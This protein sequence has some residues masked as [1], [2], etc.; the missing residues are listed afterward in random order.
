MA[1]SLSIFSRRKNS[2]G[3]RTA[4]PKSP[5]RSTLKS[6][7][8]S[9][10]TPP[11]V[12]TTRFRSRSNDSPGPASPKHLPRL[13]TSPTVQEPAVSLRRTP[14]SA[15]TSS[16]QGHQR[17]ASSQSNYVP[18]PPSPLMGRQLYQPAPLRTQRFQHYSHN[19]NMPLPMLPTPV[20]TPVTPAG[21]TPT[22]ARPGENVRKRA[23]RF[24]PT[25]TLPIS[26]PLSPETPMEAGNNSLVWHP[27]WRL[28]D[29]PGTRAD[30]RKRE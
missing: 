3:D 18:F 4:T 26:P 21:A 22:S 25:N 14:S 10:S 17:C 19:D 13:Q 28:V 1:P 12:T 16:R 7:A 29:G 27:D 2:D 23:F 20:E 5:E 30:G 15:S 9:L 6:P 11:A 8:P 24:P